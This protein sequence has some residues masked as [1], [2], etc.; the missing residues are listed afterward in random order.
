MSS[1]RDLADRLGK[2]SGNVSRELKVLTEC[3]VVGFVK[4]GTS[5]RP[6]LAYDTI[7]SEPLIAPKES[8]TPA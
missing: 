7:I 6:V 8:D 3:G 4:N 2:N 1:V 5:K